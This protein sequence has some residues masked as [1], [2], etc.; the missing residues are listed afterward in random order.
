MRIGE[1][2]RR[3]SF[4][5][6]ETLGRFSRLISRT[7]TAYEHK[8]HTIKRGHRGDVD[9]VAGNGGLTER[10]ASPESESASS[11]KHCDR[12]DNRRK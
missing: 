9:R 8:T 7:K 3:F 1:H 2:D 4:K 12:D 11:K 10:P 5:K 6:G